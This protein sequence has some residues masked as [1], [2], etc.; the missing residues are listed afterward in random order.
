M[1][2]RDRKLDEKAKKKELQIQKT[3]NRDISNNRKVVFN[4]GAGAGKTYALVESLKHIIN[5]F[6]DKLKKNNQKIICITYTNTA[7]IEIKNRLQNTNLV[8]I[9]TIHERLW[10]LIKGYKKE[11]VKL[12]V[13][14]INSILKDLEFDL[15]ED[16]NNNKYSVF[17]NYSSEL[18]NNL[19]NYLFQKR[20]LFWDN[21]R[22]QANDIRSTFSSD[23]E[24]YPDILRNINN[25]KAIAKTIYDIDDYQ[26]CIEKIK[27]NKHKY[28]E[29]IYDAQFNNDRLKR[30]VISHDTLLEYANKLFKEYPFLNRVVIDKFPY[31]LVDEYQ[32]TH[33]LVI[34]IMQS[35]H[36]YSDAKRLSLF[37]GYFGDSAQNIYEKGVGNKLRT[38][39]KKLKV[40]NKPY[41]RRSH[42]EIIDVINE[43]RNDEVYQESIFK[44]SEGGSVEFYTAVN[45]DESIVSSF[46][47]KYKEE[48]NI[49]SKNK[50]HCL[51][52]MNKKVA[53]YSGFP[54]IFNEISSTEY[55]RKNYNQIGSQLLSNELDKLGIIPLFIYKIIALKTLIDDSKTAISQ[56]FEKDIYKNLTFGDLRKIK[57]LFNEIKGNTILE[58]TQSIFSLYN[59]SK[60][61]NAFNRLVQKTFRFES[62]NSDEMF[63][64][65]LATL[66][67][68]LDYDKEAD[69]ITAK[70]KIKS[71]L[72]IPFQEYLK[73]FNFINHSELEEVLYHTYHGT[74]GREYD[75]VIIV[76]QND[77]GV[78]QKNKFSNYFKLALTSNEIK[79]PSI[80]EKFNNTK[81]LLYVACSRA[82]KNLSILYL[83][84]TSEFNNAIEEIFVVNEKYSRG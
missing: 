30:L 1:I 79:D 13:D 20:D 68:N 49:N 26:K 47:K 36:K 59:S 56:I 27:E 3:L 2:L 61:L 65:F 25:F 70:D 58:Y 51:I 57:L 18:K 6:G 4:A 77:F 73:W 28:K 14:K 80:I 37:I 44:N 54:N 45:N 64:Y 24:T 67:P 76:M 78:Q 15:Y 60:S 33:C 74:K 10:E 22:K 35:L 72:N 5:E 50:L 41:N 29:V 16:K 12:H 31:I 8:L 21:Y 83:D 53:E 62:Y 17:Q 63:E 19:R 69:V 55:Y 39:H 48:W 9:S 32:D 42:Q 82:I 81:N 40:V 52:L 43:I 46:I 84:D 66:Y 23:L 11:L 71:I 38:L 34:E 7:A 75:N